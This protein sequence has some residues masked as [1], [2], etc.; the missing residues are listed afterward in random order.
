MCMI[1]PMH[2][3]LQIR[4]MAAPRISYCTCT[5]QIQ[6]SKF[7]LKGPKPP[8]LFLQ[9]PAVTCIF[10]QHQGPSNPARSSAFALC[11]DRRQ[12]HPFPPIVPTDLPVP[13]NNTTVHHPSLMNP[14]FSPKPCHAG[15]GSSV[16]AITSHRLPNRTPPSHHARR[17]LSPSGP[18]TL[19]PR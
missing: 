8:A 9:T 18:H 6:T 3:G 11:P 12:H 17:S 15:P 13:Y 2:L 10:H 1:R 7:L 16:S 4:P 19:L 14:N 5:F